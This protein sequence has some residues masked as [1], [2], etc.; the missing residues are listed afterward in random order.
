MQFEIP[1]EAPLLP[2]TE[3]A[4]RNLPPFAWLLVATIVG[5]NVL[6]L[7]VAWHD[8]GMFALVISWGFVHLNACIAIGATIAALR[9]KRGYPQFSLV[10]HLVLSWCLPAAAIFGDRYLFALID[11]RGVC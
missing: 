1:L 9:L 7:A 4:P 8:K 5:L 11:L 6:A 10:R 3:V 2:A